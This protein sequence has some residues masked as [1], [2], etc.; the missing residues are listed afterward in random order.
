MISSD[1][2]EKLYYKR[3]RERVFKVFEIKN[4]HLTDYHI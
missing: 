4:Q 3:E 1:F 2:I